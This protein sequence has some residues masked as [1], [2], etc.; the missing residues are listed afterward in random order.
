MM[1]KMAHCKTFV[2]LCSSGTI[3][4]QCSQYPPLP[5]MPS[6]SDTIKNA[7]QACAKM[8]MPGCQLCE[9][10]SNCQDP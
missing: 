3:V 7:L 9:S 2:G 5:G 6:T 4:E 10:S 8:D 1:S